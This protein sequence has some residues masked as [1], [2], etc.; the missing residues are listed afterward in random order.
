MGGEKKLFLD[1][2]SGLKKE[3]VIKIEDKRIEYAGVSEVSETKV[4]IM[5]KL[6]NNYD[7]GTVVSKVTTFEL[8]EGKNLQ[9]HILYLGHEDLFNIKGKATITIKVTNSQSASNLGNH[10]FVQWEYWGEAIRTEDTKEIKEVDWHPLTIALPEDQNF[11]EFQLRKEKWIDQKEQTWKSGEITEREINGVKSSRWIRCKS[12]DIAKTRDIVLD[13]IQIGVG[14]VQRVSQFY[15]LPPKAIRGVGKVFGERLTKRGVNTVEELLKFKDRVAELAKIL[16]GE[17]KPSK[18]YMKKAENILENAEKRILDKEYEENM[19]NGD[20]ATQGLL[21]DMAFYNDVPLDLT[22]SD[23][24]EL[25]TPFYPFG[26]V[27]RLYD[28][29]HIGSQEAFSKKTLKVDIEFNLLQCGEPGTNGITLSWEYWNGKGWNVIKDLKD[30]TNNFTES[31]KTVEFTCP[32]DIN[33][34]QV[35]GQENYWIRVRV[36]DGGYVERA[37]VPIPE[38]IFIYYDKNYPTSWINEDVAESLATEIKFVLKEKGLTSRIG[39]AEELRAYIESKRNGIVIMAM[40]VAPDTIFNGED[41]L[42]VRYWFE[43]GGRLIWIGDWEFFYYGKSDGTRERVGEE[44]AKLVFGLG[45]SITKRVAE[46]NGY[47]MKMT[48]AGEDVIPNLAEFQSKRP[49]IISKMEDEGVVYEAYAIDDSKIY[50]DPVLFERP[51]PRYGAF[52]KFHMESVSSIGKVNTIAAELGKFVKNR[53]SSSYYVN[54]EDQFKPPQIKSVSI[55]YCDDESSD[56]SFENKS[57]HRYLQH[58]LIYNNPDFKDVTEEIKTKDKTFKPFVPLDD[59]HQTL[60]LGFDKKIEKGPISIFFSLEEFLVE[61]MPKIEWFYYSRDKKWVRLEGLD[62]TTQ[63]LTR[64]GTV[65][66]IVPTDF[67]KSS[68]FGDGLYWL[69]AVDIEDKFRTQS[70]AKVKGIYLNTTFA[71]QAESIEDELIGSSDGTGE[72]EFELVKNYVIEEEIWVNEKGTLSEEEKKKITEESGEESVSESKDETW[73]RWQAVEDFF[74]ST[75]KSRHYVVDRATGEVRFGDGVGASEISTMK[76]SIP[77]VDRVTNPVDAGGGADI[78][79]LEDAMERGPWVVKH[80]NRAVTVEDF[81]WLARQASRDVARVKCTRNINESGSVKVIIVP[82]SE[83]DKPSPSLELK[84]VVEKYLLDHCSNVV[85]LQVK[86]PEY[87]EVFVI[88]DVYPR[89]IDAAPIAEK[90]ALKRLKEFLHPLTG[91]ENGKGWEFERLIC[92]SDIYA[93]LE[94]ITE[95]DHVENVTVRMV[96]AE[97]G[98]RTIVPPETWIPSGLICSGEHQINMKFKGA[99]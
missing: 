83:E 93:L 81:E 6:L 9:E 10:D 66:F 58:C 95:I 8:F 71:I 96:R 5:D 16:S 89:S 57:P 4:D 13:T 94:G 33:P 62:D 55:T 52:V 48:P 63:N 80:R 61:D 32:N 29:F 53:F 72:Q 3:D 64:T 73:V 59:E 28:T 75:S 70:A 26:K 1:G 92:Q 7:K 11:Q 12:T 46:N 87:I 20:V 23:S 44:G 40:D 98:E 91:G 74:D 30:G 60:Y 35:N 54:V 42:A 56:E 76:T 38:D 97:E 2:I 43:N 22:P 21:P 19:A 78:E 67:A 88:A 51:K 49:V 24:Q 41:V 79:I 14:G 25:K 86:G 34:A 37:L 15:R 99:I 17:E 27:P 50:A 90:E 39:G 85:S 68:K 18:Y 65:K 84:N 31:G 47:S 82:E 77:F 69:K 36:V 45:E